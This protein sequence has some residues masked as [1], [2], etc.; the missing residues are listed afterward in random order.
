MGVQ[1]FMHSPMNIETWG[2]GLPFARL[3][4]FLCCVWGPNAMWL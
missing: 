3:L 4:H 2:H 1:N